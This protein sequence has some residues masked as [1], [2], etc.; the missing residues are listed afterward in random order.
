MHIYRVHTYSFFFPRYLIII[1]TNLLKTTHQIWM[2][3]LE[4]K[5]KVRAKQRF[6]NQNSFMTK[7]SH[8]TEYVK[9]KQEKE[10]NLR[11]NG[12]AIVTGI[13]LGKFSNKTFLVRDA[14]N[15]GRHIQYKNTFPVLHFYFRKTWLSTN[16]FGVPISTCKKKTPHGTGSFLIPQQ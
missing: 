2:M 16:V 13:Y 10:G 7:T 11:R 12:T 1:L 8:S 6:Y 3:F 15:T 9:K 5:L 4:L 14:L